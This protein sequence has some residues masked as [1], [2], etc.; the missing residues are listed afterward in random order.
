MV[1]ATVV[2]TVVGGSVVVGDGV[3]VGV[4][5]AVLVGVLVGVLRGD[6]A[7]ASGSPPDPPQAATVSAPATSAA[8]AVGRVISTVCQ[9]GQGVLIAAIAAAARSPSAMHA[10]MPMPR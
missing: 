3:L 4:M 7:T 1:V 2:A 10:G 6:A 8:I 5:V 9:A